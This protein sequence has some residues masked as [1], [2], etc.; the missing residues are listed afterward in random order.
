[1][2]ITSQQISDLRADFG[3]D[4]ESSS[5]EV[6]SDAEISRIWDR[7][8]GAANDTIRHEASLAL[9]FRQ[10]L[11]QAN[12]LH[13]YSTGATDEK[14]SQVRKH[15]KDSYEMYKPSL[16]AAQSRQTQMAI[17]TLRGRKHQDRTFP[18][19]HISKLNPDN[20]SI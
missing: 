7:V 20:S 12:K 3:D 16:D 4:D 14:L 15:L 2:A 6:F 11:N 19:N 1:M 9:M 8:S 5:T 18:A 10:V 13:D 17:T